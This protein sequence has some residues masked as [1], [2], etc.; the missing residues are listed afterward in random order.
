MPDVIGK[1]TMNSAALGSLSQDYAHFPRWK[2]TFVGRD[3][4][5]GAPAGSLRS[6]GTN[7]DRYREQQIILRLT[8]EMRTERRART[9]RLVRRFS[10]R[11]TAVRTSSTSLEA[12][13]A[14]SP[15]DELLGAFRKARGGGDAARA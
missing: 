4:R 7:N 10:I 1:F 6:D 8:F 15:A 9:R 11:P 12:G 3:L 2:G 14:S 13:R 5:V